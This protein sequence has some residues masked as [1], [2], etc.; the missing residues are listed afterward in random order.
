MMAHVSISCALG[1]GVILSMLVTPTAKA[2]VRVETHATSP[3]ISVLSWDTEGGDRA[4]LNLL[5]RDSPVSLKVRIAGKWRQGADFTTRVEKTD[6]GARYRLAIASGAELEWD[7]EPTRDQLVMSLAS[8]GTGMAAVD[9]LELTFPFDPLVAATTVLPASWDDDG[10]LRLPAVISAPDFG[11]MLLTAEP[12]S[13]IKGR[14]VGSRANHTV[15]FILELPVPKPG[16]QITLSLKPILL[17]DPKGVK[18]KQMWRAGRRGWFNI[19]QPTAQWGD[20]GNPFSAP[21]GIL[22]NNVVSDPVSCLLGMWADQALLTPSFSKDIRIADNVRRTVDWWLDHRTRPTGEVVAYYDLVDMLDAN[23]GQLIA[24]WD[25]VEA[26]SDHQWLAKRIDRLEFVADYLI[27]RD[28]DDDGL[29]ESVTSGNYGAA[30]DPARSDSAY[31]TIAAG[32][33]NAYCNSLIYRGFRCLADLEK[34]L[35]RS[36]Q[37]RKY[38]QRADRLKANYYTTFYNPRTGW[39]VWWKS[40]DGEIHDLSAPMITSLAVC[41]GLVTPEQGRPMMEKLWAEIDKVGFKRF[42]LGVP[43]TLHPVRR[44]DYLIGDGIAGAPKKE[45]GSDTF[46]HYLNGGCLV[47]DAVYFITAMHIVGD[48]EKGDKVL[49]A[50]LSRQEKGVFPNGGGFQNGVINQYP[51]GAEFYTWDGETT[52]YEGH[53][54]YSFS[55]LQAILL[56]QP[57]FRA[58]LFRPLG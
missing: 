45:D 31:D 50:M 5:R 28:I 25:Y 39:L 32:H 17:P 36:E 57:E 48:G 21:S 1:I 30:H 22:A 56:R 14:L 44:G 34:Q 41:Y 51:H 12:Q 26:S 13:G 3:A 18:D 42:D 19:F 24:S 23:A 27:K 20:Q 33:K 15:D 7:V 10:S 4:K 55:F 16:T 11:Q 8:K 6:K 29:I 53:L 52:G 46:Q 40:E 9:G 43:L 47:S 35:G 58:K 2:S 49:H 37:S 38:A 54:T